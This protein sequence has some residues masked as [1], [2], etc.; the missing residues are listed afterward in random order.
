[1][2]KDI[3]PLNKFDGGLNNSTNARDINDADLADAQNVDT[4]RAGAIKSLGAFE[5]FFSPATNTE[6]DGVAAVDG[7]GIAYMQIDTKM[8][9]DEGDAT[10]GHYIA[11][12]KPAGS[13]AKIL[14]YQDPVETNGTTVFEPSTFQLPTAINTID[15][16]IDYVYVD[17]GLR[18]FD[19]NIESTTLP[20]QKISYIPSGRHYFKGANSNDL[21]YT[22]STWIC[23]NQFITAPQGG[24][25]DQTNS[26]TTADTPTTNANSVHLQILTNSG[27]GSSESI[28]IGWGDTSTDAH[29]YEFYASFVYDGNQE[30]MLASLGSCQLGGGTTDSNGATFV[31]YVNTGGENAPSWNKRITGVN[32]YY[33]NSKFSEDI[34]YLIGKFDCVAYDTTNIAEGASLSSNYA[35]LLGEKTGKTNNHNFLT[36][37][38]AGVFHK[39]PPTIFTHAISSGI[40]SN[41]TSTDCFY[42]TAALVNRKLYV[43]NIKQK[44]NESPTTIRHYP[45]RLLKSVNNKFD[46]LPDNNFIDVNIRDGENIVKLIGMGNRL[47]MFK[48]STLFVIAVAGGEEYLEATYPHLGIKHPNAVTKTE[49]GLFWVNKHGAYVTMGDQA[50]ANVTRGKID[51]KKWA[52]FVT[53]NSICGYHPKAKQYVVIKDSS[54]IS[55]VSDTTVNDIMVWNLQTNSWNPGFNKIGAS[56]NAKCTNLINYTDSS[57]NPHLLTF[58]HSG[59]IEEWK[60]IEDRSSLGTN[61]FKFKT[62]EL[63]G[64]APNIRKKFYK[65]YITYSCTNVSGAPSVKMDIVGKSFD[66]QITLDAGID[67]SNTNAGE[68]KTAEFVVNANDKSKVANVYSASIVLEGDAV[69]ESFEINDMSMIIRMKSVK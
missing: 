51:N 65:L 10:N 43:G 25:V 2:P 45:D 1:M 14:F 36:A 44:T 68:F 15:A 33:R 9:N 22:T 31:P 3:L 37:N 61:R 32:I 8:S 69:H 18:L 46:V 40:N 23:E 7:F 11:I 49:T 26:T 29:T 67:F 66:G 64:N 58:I 6:L 41:A 24:D 20:P 63:T 34:K 17:G 13:Q 48:E 55:G 50:P 54:A 57:G 16:K 21:E 53:D 30:S 60:S 35:V 52:D 5:S 62:K 59:N 28:P 38:D 27:Q 12:H 19:S 47:Y 4:N 42:K 56:T 39:S